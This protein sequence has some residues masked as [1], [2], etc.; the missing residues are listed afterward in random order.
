[1]YEFATRYRRIKMQL[2]T[3]IHVF[4]IGLFI[5]AVNNVK[6]D[7]KELDTEDSDPFYV[8]ANY[9]IVPKNISYY[10]ATRENIDSYQL[11]PHG[12]VQV[13]E[14]SFFRKDKPVK[15]IIHGWAGNAWSQMNIR[16]KDAFLKFHDV[17]VISV[18]WGMDA[19]GPYED[20]VL[21]IPS[22]GKQ[23]STFIDWLIENGVIIDKFHV[24]GYSAG[25]HVASSAAKHLKRGKIPYITGLDPAK[26]YW[27]HSSE[28]LDKQDGKY[29]EIIHT[30]SRHSGLNFSIGHNDFYPNGGYL[31]PGTVFDGDSHSRA[32]DYFAESIENGGFTANQCANFDEILEMR[33]SNLSQLHMGGINPKKHVGL[34]YL[35]TN[36]FSPYSQ[37]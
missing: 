7:T 12:D 6:P 33:C 32:Y 21:A 24:I 14:S 8:T 15:V 26:T 10:L 18:D 37:G 4:T 30:N 29:V 20:V 13:L 17:N 11:I 34:F 22:V 27:K 2:S 23:V 35:T 16:V 19:A 31:M 36:A 1:M 25:A 9:T 3:K 28:R 5:L